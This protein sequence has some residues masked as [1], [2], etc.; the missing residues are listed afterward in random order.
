MIIAL[1]VF[2]GLI[3]VALLVFT[4]CL[5]KTS[6]HADALPMRESSFGWSDL[7][8]LPDPPAE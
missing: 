2:G 8:G 4:I 7:S 5:N 3:G 1:G 6:A